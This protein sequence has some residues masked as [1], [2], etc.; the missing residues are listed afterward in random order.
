MSTTIDVYPTTHHLPFIEDTDR[1]AEELFNEVLARHTV[2]PTLTIT[3]YHYGTSRE[4]T[5]GLSWSPG[6]SLAFNYRIHNQNR[7]HSFPFCVDINVE[8]HVQE[9][10]ITLYDLSPDI[11][12]E[13]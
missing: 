4:V 6:L 1:R 2:E 7:G 11:D 10:D 9:C 12:Y 5:K 13:P 3:P 8:Y